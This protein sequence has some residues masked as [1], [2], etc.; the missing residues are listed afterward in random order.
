MTTSCT[1]IMDT[2]P[3]T[4]YEEEMVWNSKA[5]AEAFI[6]GTYGDVLGSGEYKNSADY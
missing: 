3:F 6:V 1:D 4:S 5:T 2:K